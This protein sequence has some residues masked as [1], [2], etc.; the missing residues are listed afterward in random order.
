MDTYTGNFKET[1]GS[2]VTGLRISSIHNITHSFL[3][4]KKQSTIMYFSWGVHYI[5]EPKI[6]ECHTLKLHHQLKTVKQIFMVI[7]YTPNTMMCNFY[8]FV[9][10]NLISIIDCIINTGRP[11]KSQKWQR[12]TIIIIIIIN[13]GDCNNDLCK[14]WNVPFPKSV[15]W[16]WTNKKNCAHCGMVPPG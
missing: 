11:L 10:L 2:K 13:Y 6:T 12:F 3:V 7:I 1:R 9:F 16:Y 8:L 5:V 14:R 15:L 4:D